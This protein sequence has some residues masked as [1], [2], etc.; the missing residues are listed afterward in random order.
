M[1]QPLNVSD[2]AANDASGA[3]T[4]KSTEL[5]IVP[6]TIASKA[7]GVWMSVRVRNL[8]GRGF[9]LPAPAP[10]PEPVVA[11]FA[12]PQSQDV[13]SSWS[14]YLSALELPLIGPSLRK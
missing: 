6:L 2:Q 1:T 4:F 3:T 8:N 5:R 11:G 9:A 14:L 10:P 12:A 13:I 7:F